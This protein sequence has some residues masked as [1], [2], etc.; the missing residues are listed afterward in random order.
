MNF[1]NVDLHCHS[2]V[3]DGTLS[4]EAVVRRAAANG[5]D[6]LSL[7]DHDETGGLA[8]ARAAAEAA[9][10]ALIPG[11]EVSVSW[12]G[13]TIHI[14]GVGI[15]ESSEA[16]MAGLRRTRASR[17]VRATK[18][19]AQL[20]AAGIAGSLEGAMAYADNPELI[21]RTHFARY[22]V[23]K[24]HARDVGAVFKRYLARGLPGYVPHQWAELAE[25]VTWIRDA[26][27]RAVV[28]HPG[29]YQLSR[30]ER[31]RFFGEFKDAGGEGIEVVTGSH[32]R[33]QFG[34]FA[35]VAREFG[36]L[37]SR[38]SDFHSPDEGGFDLGAVPP[39][40]ADLKPVWYDW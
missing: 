3:S 37:A 30:Q 7:T 40:P 5:V 36:F 29:R 33:D 31:W 20:D 13:T 18:I 1:R 38:G 16:L 24:G 27:G 23:E 8:E 19:A 12:G 6:A 39:L 28:A 15:D 10:I 9:G 35:G 4:P 22:L 11:V 26:G 2:T 21:G 14:V 25:A 34:E 17:Q 32:T